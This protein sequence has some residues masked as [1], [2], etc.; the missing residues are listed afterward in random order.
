VQECLKKGAASA[1]QE[2]SIHLGR[3]NAF[4]ASALLLDGCGCQ[5]QDAANGYS[6]RKSCNTADAA[7]QLQLSHFFEKNWTG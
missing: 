6:I 4:F 1:T 2:L 5:A 3:V 7:F